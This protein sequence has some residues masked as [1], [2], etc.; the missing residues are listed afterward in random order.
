LGRPDQLRCLVEALEKQDY[1]NKE[2]ILEEGN[3][4]ASTARN[5]GAER[6]RGEIFVF[7]D[8]DVIIPA[9]NWLTDL[10]LPLLAESADDIGLVSS[11]FLLSPD[12]T[13]FERSIAK[14]FDRIEFSPVEEL[15]ESDLAGSNCLAIKKKLF[16]SIGGWDERY[17]TSEDN[18]MR[19]RLR[20][21]GLK[22]YM[23]PQTQIY[24][25]RSKTLTELTGKCVWYYFNSA[26]ATKS[27][28]DTLGYRRLNSVWRKVAY[29]VALLFGF[30]ADLIYWRTKRRFAFRLCDSCWKAVLSLGVDQVRIAFI[31]N[32]LS[33][34]GGMEKVV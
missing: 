29:I 14:Q 12:A 19:E 21:L 10:V 34:R 13:R 7:I 26:M 5:R 24:H 11:S 15:T 8:D 2:V 33:Q 31:V 6:A 9:T 20:H 23:A 27:G 32:V 25:P 4:N 1:P 16:Q 30:L 22:P 18:E 28:A 3:R 17:V